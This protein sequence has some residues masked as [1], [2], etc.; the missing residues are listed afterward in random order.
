MDTRIMHTTTIRLFIFLPALLMFATPVVAGGKKSVTW[1][2]FSEGIVQAKQ[3]KKKVLIDVYTD[4]CGWCKKMDVTTYGD[5]GVARYLTDHYVT[6]KLD[7]ESSQKVHYQGTEYTEQELAAAFGISGFP[8]T[9]FLQADGEPITVFPGYADP[10]QFQTVISFI[11]ED[12][13]LSKS[14]DEYVALRKKT[15]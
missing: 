1:M 11:A 15:R 7:A 2:A 12:H 6:V 3:T 9:V 5:E 4:W 8:S 10:R 14:F 13:Y